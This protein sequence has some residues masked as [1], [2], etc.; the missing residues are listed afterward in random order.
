MNL[1]R[2]DD[3]ARD[4][5]IGFRATTARQGHEAGP[6]VRRAFGEYAFDIELLGAHRVPTGA[7]ARV[8]I[9]VTPAGP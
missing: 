1:L 5:A 3:T 8:V 7:T 9:T 2:A 6:G 4:L